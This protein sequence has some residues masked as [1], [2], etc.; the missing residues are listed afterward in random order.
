MVVKEP[1]LLTGGT[2]TSFEFAAA[3]EFSHT[4][5]TQGHKD[6]PVRHYCMLPCCSCPDVWIRGKRLST[7]LTSTPTST[8][9]MRC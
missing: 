7:S 1:R 4:L 5:R 2:Y 6:V 8:Q 3:C 9:V